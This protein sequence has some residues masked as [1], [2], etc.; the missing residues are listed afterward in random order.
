MNKIL[1]IE[2]EMELTNQLQKNLELSGYQV[3]TAKEGMSGLRK[4]YNENPDIIILERVLPNFNGCQIS[5]LLRR[6]VRYYD[7][8]IIMLSICAQDK[9]EDFNGG[10]PDA[11]IH[12]PF[13]SAVLLEKIAELLLKREACKEEIRKKMVERDARWMKEHYIP[14]LGSENNLSEIKTEVSEDSVVKV[15]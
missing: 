10:R 7:L 2:N 5:A 11:I 12:K 8:P 3:I 6:D 14:G 1:L 13:N 4:A 9:L 15:N